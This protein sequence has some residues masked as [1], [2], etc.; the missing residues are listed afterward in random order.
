MWARS[1]SKGIF[2]CLLSTSGSKAIGLVSA[3]EDGNSFEE[4]TDVAVFT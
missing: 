3:G 2:S 1:C 4:S